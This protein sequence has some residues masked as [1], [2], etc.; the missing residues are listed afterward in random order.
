M[1][2]LLLS[3]AEKSAVAELVLD[4]DDGL[5]ADG[6]DDDD[7]EDCATAS[8]DSANSTAAVVILRVFGMDE[9]PVI[10]QN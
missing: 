5:V 8:V 6:V 1:P 2:S 4:E 10:G 7:D 9:S 3:A